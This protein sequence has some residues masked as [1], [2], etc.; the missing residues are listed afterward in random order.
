[1]IPALGAAE[2]SRKPTGDYSV[3]LAITESEIRKERK[4]KGLSIYPSE[5][6]S[7]KRGHFNWEML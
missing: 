3:A 6:E 5:T 4:L 1:M 2:L 7:S